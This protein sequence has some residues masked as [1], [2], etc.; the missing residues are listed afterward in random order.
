MRIL[1]VV[2][3]FIPEIG[4]AA[5]IYLDLAKALAKREHVVNV[6]TS[7]PREFN[8]DKTD[9]G[10]EFPLEEEI[11]GVTIYRCKHL[12]NR[13]NIFV[14]GLEHFYLPYY[15]FKKYR[16]IGKKYDVCLMYIPP[17]PLY[18]L[19]RKI[20]HCDGTPSVLNFQ[21]FHPQELTDVGVLK[22]PI[23]IKI[24]EYIEGEAN[25]HADHITVLSHGGIEYV[26]K[27]GADPKKVAHIY[28]SVSLFEFNDLLHRKDFKDMEGIEDKFLI[29]YAGIL[30][31][32]QGIDN[33]LDSAR[34]LQ[35]HDD[36]LFY[37]AGDGSERQC[38]ED[39]IHREG[40]GDVR[41]LPFLP[42]AEYFNLVNSSDASFVSLDERMIAPCLPGKIINLM[43]CSQPIIAMVAQESE[44]A[45]VIRKAECGI[46]VKPGDIEGIRSAILYLRD[47]TPAR[48]A[49][50][51]NGR[52]YLEKNMSLEKNVVLYEEIF[53]TLVG[54]GVL[55][56]RPTSSRSEDAFGGLD[57]HGT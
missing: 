34:A 3:Y 12:A 37:I 18:Y 55:S 6:I 52:R 44:T 17:L 54:D 2:A 46:V 29:S 43:A 49:M 38:L 28:N 24:L 22:N 15:Y 23:M 42:R 30:S 1:L 20:K 47:N 7:Y 26:Q 56:K 50:G 45:D 48:E 41:L 10:K 27:R 14:R 25:R 19:A 35:D 11:D 32:Y 39:R 33:I 4:S 51:D 57:S 21:D 5:H 13:D 16:E 8:L 40:I 36:I 31:P 9:Q 53:H